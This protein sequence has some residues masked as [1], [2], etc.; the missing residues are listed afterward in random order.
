MEFD[1]LP[2]AGPYTFPAIRASV[3][4]NRDARLHELNGIFRAYSHAATAVV[5]FAGDDVNHERRV[6]WHGGYEFRLSG[7]VLRVMYFRF[8]IQV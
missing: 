3:L 1:D 5:A 4:D 7:F 6:G 8:R 2:G